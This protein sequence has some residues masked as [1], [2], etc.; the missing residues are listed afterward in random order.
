MSNPNFGNLRRSKYAQINAYKGVFNQLSKN[1]ILTKEER[2][3]AS[4]I[5]EKIEELRQVY[6][7]PWQNQ[8]ET[9]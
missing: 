5:V 9:K 1:T 6:N 7:R 8:K 3:K 4:E 2:Q